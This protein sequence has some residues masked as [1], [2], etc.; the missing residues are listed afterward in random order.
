MNLYSCKGNYSV[1]L[2][3]LSFIFAVIGNCSSSSNSTTWYHTP[4]RRAFQ[5]CT[6]TYRC[7]TDVLVVCETGGFDNADNKVRTVRASTLRF[8]FSS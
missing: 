2:A 5:T 4:L 8:F 3:A 6:G 1:I 7:L